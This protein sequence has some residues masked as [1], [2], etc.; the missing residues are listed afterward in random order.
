[1]FRRIEIRGILVDGP[2]SI[3]SLAA[4]PGPLGTETVEQIWAHLARAF[5]PAHHPDGAITRLGSEAATIA[6]SPTSRPGT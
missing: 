3:A 1:V 4:R 5:P 2:K 6:T